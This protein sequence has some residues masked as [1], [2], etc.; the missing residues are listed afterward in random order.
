MYVFLV[1]R[2]K[3]DYLCNRDVFSPDLSMKFQISQK[4]SIR[5][6]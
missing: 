4:L 6:P 1:F 2:E 5:F 3:I